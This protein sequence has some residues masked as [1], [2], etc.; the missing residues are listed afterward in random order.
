MKVLKNVDVDSASS[1]KWG[2]MISRSQ[3]VMGTQCADYI[4][5]DEKL[6][7]MSRMPTIGSYSNDLFLISYL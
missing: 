6:C 1:G 3:M 5:T 4:S 7:N 2:S